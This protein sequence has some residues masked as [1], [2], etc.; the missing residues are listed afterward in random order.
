MPRQSP[1]VKFHLAPLELHLVQKSMQR[2][3]STELPTLIEACLVLVVMKSSRTVQQDKT[4][5]RVLWKVDMEKRRSV[6]LC[7]IQTPKLRQMPTITRACGRRELQWLM[8]SNLTRSAWTAVQM[9]NTTSNYSKLPALHTSQVV[10][11]TGSRTLQNSSWWLYANSWLG[12]RP[13][14]SYRAPLWNEWIC[15]L[16]KFSMTSTY[17]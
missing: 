3:T 11:T 14:S 9:S 6:C 17:T 8:S 15:A 2:R 12:K 1:A 13:S 7:C 10:S 5:C 16:R 4:S